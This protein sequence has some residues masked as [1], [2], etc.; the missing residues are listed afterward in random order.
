MKTLKILGLALLCF[1]NVLAQSNDEA[2]NIKIKSLEK[3]FETVL[4]SSKAAGFAIAIVKGNE[5]VYAK[6]L[7]IVI[8][9]IKRLQLATPFL[10][11]VHLLKL[12]Q[13]P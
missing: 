1:T 12:L 8:L 13:R 11:L 6:G 3:D 5:V 9:K 2:L 10:L 7:G 4:T